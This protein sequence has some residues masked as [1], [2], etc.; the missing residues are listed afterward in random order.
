MQEESKHSIRLLIQEAQIFDIKIHGNKSDPEEWKSIAYSIEEAMKTHTK[1]SII[2]GISKMK[3]FNKNGRFKEFKNNALL[4][5]M[6][7]EMK[8]Q[9]TILELRNSG[10]LFE[11]Q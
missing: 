10:R 3:L 1:E 5:H 6:A 9:R 7:N 4:I 8:K 11:S 2:A